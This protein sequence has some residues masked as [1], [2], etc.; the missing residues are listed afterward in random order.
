MSLGVKHK[1]LIEFNKIGDKLEKKLIPF[2]TPISASEYLEQK[3][4]L[5]T[6][7]LW[8]RNFSINDKEAPYISFVSQATL[9]ASSYT[10]HEDVLNDGNFSN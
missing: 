4:H 5:N 3:N 7:Y 6:Y 1:D 8:F 10:I 9:E 2:K